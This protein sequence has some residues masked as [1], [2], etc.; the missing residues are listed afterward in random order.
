MRDRP[1]IDFLGMELAALRAAERR[2]ARRA[3]RQI[4]A[5][6]N[7][8]NETRGRRKPTVRTLARMRAKEAR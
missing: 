4:A 6:L 5:A 8:L 7:A 3:K 2:G 1:A